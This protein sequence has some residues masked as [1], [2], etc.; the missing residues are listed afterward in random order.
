MI[1]KLNEVQESKLKDYVELGLKIGF[2]T[3][4]INFEKA[5]E[6]VNLAYKCGGLEPPK[7]FIYCKSPAEAITKINVMKKGERSEVKYIYTRFNGQSDSYFTCFYEF[8]RKECGLISE[9]DKMLGLI[10]LVKQC[11]WCYL[12]KD[13]AF[14]CD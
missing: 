8:F 6:A 13:I 9:T 4:P 10:E 11:G 7:E 5:K 14:I 3:K 12:Y 1:E 2:S